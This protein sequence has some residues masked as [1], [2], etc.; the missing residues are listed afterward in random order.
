[1]E[2]FPGEIRSVSVSKPSLDD[3]FI[4]HTGHRFW[5]ESLPERA[6]SNRHP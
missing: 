4:R 6:E 2:Q 5:H 1:M 3:V